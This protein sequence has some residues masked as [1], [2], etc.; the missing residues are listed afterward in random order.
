MNFYCYCS[1][2]FRFFFNDTASPDID[3][4]RHTLSLHDSLPILKPATRGPTGEVLARRFAL[5]ASRMRKAKLRGRPMPAAD[6][7]G[8]KCGR[9]LPS[10]PGQ[11]AGA[12]L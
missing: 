8:L 2:L 5:A 10:Q 1:P 7:P 11:A 4:Y 9:A 3:T 6:F 12:A